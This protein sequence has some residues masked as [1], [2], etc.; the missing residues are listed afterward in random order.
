MAKTL[1]ELLS[2][3]GL[4]TAPVTEK[5]ASSNLSST[6]EVDEVLRSLGVGST[7]TVK[8]ASENTKSNGGSMKSM[9]DIY[10]E[11]CGAAPAETEKTAAEVEAEAT[12]AAAATEITEE[13]SDSDFGSMVGAYFNESLSPYVE[14]IAKDLEAEAGAGHKPLAGIHGD[15]SLSPVLGA[16][17]DPQL[18]KNH[19]ATGGGKI[20][21]MTGNTSPYS[22]KDA[23]LAKQILKREKVVPGG[24]F[25]E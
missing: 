10:E 16:T 14:K 8:T 12:A 5:T 15:G 11:I 22:L 17:G 23:A 21:A 3:T 6:D 7:A 4:E 1:K 18:A 24:A 19:Q 9:S 20:N 25:S 2:E 13:N